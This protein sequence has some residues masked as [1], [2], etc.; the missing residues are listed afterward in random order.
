MEEEGLR[1]V[2]SRGLAFVPE[3][4]AQA[5]LEVSPDGVVAPIAKVA[6]CSYGLLMRSASRALDYS[7]DW[8]Q[9]SFTIR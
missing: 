6:C 2:H 1:V 7:S 9:A 8:M 5:V 3:D 4:V